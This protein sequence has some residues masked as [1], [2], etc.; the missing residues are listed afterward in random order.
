[1]KRT[2]ILSAILIL[3]G[4]ASLNNSVSAAA[5]NDNA[6]GSAKKENPSTNKPDKEDKPNQNKE[7]N[8][9]DIKTSAAAPGQVKKTNQ[10]TITAKTKKE[11]KL[12]AT[13]LKDLLLQ[14]GT[15]SGKVKGLK[16]V[17]LS[18]ASPS[19]QLRKRHAIQGLISEI[20]GNV[21]TL[22]HQIQQDRVNF[23]L[24][25]S[26]TVITGKGIDASGSA[27]LTVGQRIAA[28]GENTDEGLL[29]K[30]IHI[31][32]GKATGVFNKQPDATPSSEI[33]PTATV[34]GSP[35]ATP[36]ATETATPTFT[37][38]L[39]PAITP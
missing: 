6:Q 27:T 7:T 28:V 18:E 17:K 13:K 12:G 36:T 2:F 14:S 11:T 4:V 37:P 20:G 35:T 31:I 25:N 1:M 33:T 34:S 24:T 26:Q 16:N 30:R 19:A 9:S 23:V 22:V 29:A 38:T 15:E 8:P 32:P 5:K 10:L 3:A 21:I 39:T